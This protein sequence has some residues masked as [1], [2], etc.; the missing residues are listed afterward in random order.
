MKRL[1]IM[2]NMQKCMSGVLTTGWFAVWLCFAV[3]A[4]QAQ[5]NFLTLNTNGAWTW[6]NDQRALYYR[7]ILYFGY[8]TFQINNNGKSALS[9]YTPWTGV[10]SNLWTGSLSESDEHDVPGLLVKQDGTM[11]AIYT[12]HQTDQFFTCR[13][14]TSTNPVSS[15]NRGAEHTNDSIRNPGNDLRQSVST[16]GGG[17][18][19]LQLWPQLEL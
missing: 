1:L 14:S 9:T 15:A 7:G 10:V 18:K 2:K 8:A 13:L 3:Q 12:R 5:T 6:F 4:S 16:R 19:N 11:L 17:R